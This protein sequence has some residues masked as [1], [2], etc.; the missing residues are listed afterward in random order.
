MMLMYSLRFVLSIVMLFFNSLLFADT[1]SSAIGQAFSLETGDLLYTEK[2]I[3]LDKAQHQ[4]IYSEPDGTVFARK[5]IDF[6]N[7]LI[8][9]SFQ[10]LNERNG[11]SIDVQQIG[12]GFLVRYQKQSGSEEKSD[13]IRDNANMVID[14]GFDA[15]VRQYWQ[16]LMSGKA[17]DIEYLVP[18]KRTTFSFRFQ[19]ADC[20]A[21]TLSS[22][23]CFT[24]APVSWLVKM[25]VDPIVV[26]Y[27]STTLRLMRFTG[28]ANISNT[29]GKYQ[30]V[31]I[32]YQYHD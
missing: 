29:A 20:L 7:S 13:I 30:S 14:A 11:E 26:T 32:H 28:R 21:D 22:A 16:P 10:Q 31:D 19:Q 12:D 24:L 15:F 6:S 2:H 25:A 4:V 18:S 5:Q 1:T 17:M 27:D 8:R 23:V 9:P 3:K